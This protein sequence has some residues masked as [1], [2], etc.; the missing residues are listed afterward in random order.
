[1]MTECP[2]LLHVKFQT[3]FQFFP[4]PQKLNRPIVE[5]LIDC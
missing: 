1:M 5:Y 4:K 2:F 3:Y